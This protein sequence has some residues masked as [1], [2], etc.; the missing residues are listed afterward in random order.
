[1][2]LDRTVPKISQDQ[3]RFG[4][5]KD[6]RLEMDRIIQ[7][8][9]DA[10]HFPPATS[11]DMVFRVLLTAIQGAAVARLCGRMVLGAD[12]D[13]M[14]RDT[15]EAALT[16]CRAGFPHG[17]EPD[18]PVHGHRQSSVR[19]S[20]MT[21]SRSSYLF[22]PALLALASITACKGESSTTAAAAEAPT[23][24][25]VSTAP[26]ESRPID[27]YLRVTG[28]LAADEQAEVSAETA[29]RVTDTPVER[30]SQVQKGALLVRISAAETSAQ[31]EEADANAAQIESRLGLVAGQPFD[32]TQVPDVMNAKASLDF[33]ESEFGRIKSL[34]D[35]KVVS[36]SEYDQRRTQVEAARQQYIV[37][38]N[39]ARQSYRS[40]EAA[41]ARVALA[42][43]AVADTGVRAPFSGLVAERAVSVGDYV[44]RG[45]RVAT[46]VSVDPLRIELTVPEQS[47]SLVKVGQ[48]V[49]LTLDAYPGE[50]FVGNVRFVSPSLRAD[51]RAL[52]VEAM[53]TNGDGRLKPGMFATAWIQQPQ[54]APA[55]LVPKAALETIAGT[56]RVYVVKNGRVEERIVTTGET[57]GDSIEVTSGVAK[58][59]TVATQP[60]GRLADGQTVTTR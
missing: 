24:V 16:G 37:A 6:L 11:A 9:I 25:A 23:P 58:G 18:D 8:A 22:F 32:P 33:A 27:R 44:T 42:R 10:G 26:V 56:T 60:N 3:G 2:F 28:S 19:L 55:L 7:N 51:Q 40:L 52:T 38:Q 30:G 34:L 12:A 20:I 45:A 46:V 57:V 49:K 53:A 15:L 48:P 47:V 4:F 39:S 29:G 14:A 43:K 41:R 17:F 21:A 50:E 13:A 59:E 1:M 35:Q 54:G 36:Q 5:L 31:L